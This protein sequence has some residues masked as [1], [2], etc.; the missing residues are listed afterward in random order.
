MA[1]FNPNQGFGDHKDIARELFT[2][3]I[4]LLEEFEIAYFVISGTLLGL[5]RH[6]DFIPWDDDIDLIV[7]SS[8]F[9]KMPQ[10]VERYGDSLAFIKRDYLI[11]TFFKDRGLPITNPDAFRNTI[12]DAG[13]SGQVYTGPYNWP[14]VDLFI[15][16]GSDTDV[17]FF[18]QDWPV[19]YFYP[20]ERV[21]FQGI[22]VTIPRNPDYFLSRNYGPDYMTVAVSSNFNHRTETSRPPVRKIALHKIN[23]HI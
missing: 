20:S 1:F 9:E 10:I 11:K 2:K 5:V 22:L 16:S 15:F 13:N 19:E 21:L 14:F 4:S 3:T 17:R 12:D 8:I 23:E 18:H 6:Q 7:D